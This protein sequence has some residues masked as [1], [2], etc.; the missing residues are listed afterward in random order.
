MRIGTVGAD[1]TVITKGL[2]A[3]RKVVLATLS[4]PLP[5]RASQADP[6]QLLRRRRLRR[7]FTG[8]PPAGFG[9]NARAGN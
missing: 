5:S 1:R 3:G 8:G 2:T 9:G 4:E 7:D 6:A